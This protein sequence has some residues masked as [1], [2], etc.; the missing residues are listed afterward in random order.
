MA[1]HLILLGPLL[2]LVVT[3]LIKAEEEMRGLVRTANSAGFTN[4]RNILKCRGYIYAQSKP[5]L[6][7]RGGDPWRSQSGHAFSPIVFFSGDEPTWHGYFYTVVLSV[8]AILAA[9]CDSQYWYRMTQLG[10][11]VRTALSSS[12]YRKSLRLSN[13]ARGSFAGNFYESSRYP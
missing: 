2:C 4:W 1:I 11:G 12:I 5:T 9:T 3:P 8:S 6:Y 13:K 10:L 7:I